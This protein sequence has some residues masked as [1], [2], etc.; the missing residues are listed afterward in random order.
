MLNR[1]TESVIIHG[2]ENDE[3]NKAPWAFVFGFGKEPGSVDI[4]A[5]SNIVFT[6]YAPTV[7]EIAERLGLEYDEFVCTSEVILAD[8]ETNSQ[9]GVIKP[10]TIGAHMLL[11][12]CKK[13]G[14]E[15]TGFHFLHKSIDTILE[16]YPIEQR[17]EIKGRPNVTVKIDG[18]FDHEEPFLTSA[19][20]NMNLIASVVKAEPGY[21]D[22]LD[23]PVGYLPR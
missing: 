11:M 10:G 14:K 12:S 6:Y 22:A 4:S 15:V 18:L 1:E 13:D 20:P 23:I 16:D 3:N 17:I 19:S 7:I 9:F 5:V 21:K 2:G 8:K